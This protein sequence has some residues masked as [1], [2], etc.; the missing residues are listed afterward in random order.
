MNL[1]SQ[2]FNGQLGEDLNESLDSGDFHSLSIVVAFAKNSGVLRL[3]E[4]MRRFRERGGE[5][6]LY[7]GVDMNGTSYEAL[8]NLLPIATTLR[9]IHDEN[10]QTFHTKLFN[11]TGE[12]HS[13]LIVGS[14]N[15]TL[16]GLW[17]NYES[18][19]RLDLDH[20]DAKDLKVQQNVS[21][22]L[23][24]LQELSGTVKLLGDQDEIQ[25]LLA[26][27]YVEKE[28]KTLIRRRREFESV[29]RT[30][31]FGAGP[32]AHVPSLPPVES[33]EPTSRSV[34]S[35]ADGADTRPKESMRPTSH[36]PESPA[37]PDSSANGDSDRTNESGEPTLW[38]ETRKMTGGSRNIIDL[39]KTSLLRSG[40]VA[41]TQFE[42]ENPALMRGAVEFFDVDPED[43][44]R[45]KEIIINFEGTDYAGNTIKFPSGE[46]ANGTWRVQLK[47]TSADGAKL[48]QAFK[49]LTEDGGNEYLLPEKIVTF[50]KLRTDYYYF[51]VFLETEVE[52]FLEVSEVT[53]YNGRNTT[54]RRLGI[55]H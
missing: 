6:H 37:G 14:H 19:L 20:S 38:L 44:S 34:A 55:L 36:I 22:Y 45:E 43:T 16:G 12:G 40:D 26:N 48:T 39:S 29:S 18:S 27:R 52:E 35:A 13:T 25:E 4:A 1:L 32:R 8:S 23:K 49:E 51:S 21:A 50:T 24:C 54:A 41:G 3:R 7:V 15:L 42:L 28:V 46:H 2:P 11:F 10:G 9:V 31:L 30:P 47:G 17:T 33:G 53:A 5:L